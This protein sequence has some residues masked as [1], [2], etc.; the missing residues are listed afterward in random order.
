MKRERA[1]ALGLVLLLALLW[2]PGAAGKSDGSLPPPSCTRLTSARVDA[3]VI[4]TPDRAGELAGLIRQ[5]KPGTTI[6][7]EDG[8]YPLGG[9]TLYLARPGVTLRSRSGRRNA[10]ILDGEG[11]RTATL[12][13]VR[14]PGVTVADLTLRQARHH[15]VHL[16]GGADDATLHNLHLIDAGQQLVKVN[17]SHDGQWND[18]GLLACSRLELTAEGRAWVEGHPVGQLRCYTGGID[19]HQAR[20]WTVRDNEFEGIYCSNGGLAEHA[21]HF[22]QGSRDTRVERNVIRNCARGIGFG[23][24]A[25]G[26]TRAYPDQEPLPGYAGHLGGVIARNVVTSNLGHGF[27]T[28]IGLEQ[29]WRAQVFENRVE[30]DAIGHGLAID[31]RFPQSTPWITNNHI[32][33]PIRVRDGARPILGHVETQKP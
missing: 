15:L 29:A 33:S 24:G 21:I 31:V 20:D 5:V 19:A 9:E 30:T 1:L 22:W 25:S 10:V 32:P 13:E 26:A 6:L 17:P 12:V 27:D 2:T 16:A 7:L 28:G 11:Y 14:A 18:R 4:M 23:L 3:V 8:R